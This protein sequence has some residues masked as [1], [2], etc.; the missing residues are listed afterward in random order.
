MIPH[1]YDMTLNKL[2]DGGAVITA[3]CNAAHKLRRILAET[4]IESTVYELDCLQHL[5]NIWINGAAI[6]KF[7]NEFLDDSLKNI[8]SFLRVSPDLAN[9]ICAFHKEFSLDA[10]YP[11]G[12]G[13][14]FCSWVI[15][16][17]P[18]EYIIHA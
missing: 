17:Y 16:N 13:K 12:C 3:T 1:P 5:R 10:N 9:I 11:K 2:G 18:L 15:K 6:T 4:Y 7:M 14:K 8:F